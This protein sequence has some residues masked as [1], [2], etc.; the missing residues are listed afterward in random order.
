MVKKL[1]L[2]T[3]LKGSKKKK[4]G[5]NV[6]FRVDSIHQ[7]TKNALDATSLRQEIISSNIANVNTKDYKAKQVIF[8][9]ELK[10]A[11]S[12]S[13]SVMRATDA[14]HFGVGSNV[15]SVQARIV[16]DSEN[17]TMNV[18]GNSIDIELEMSKM[19]A[20][21]I[22]YNALIQSTS[23]RLNDYHSVIKG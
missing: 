19:A 12:S 3:F 18:D 17:L 23:S 7:L 5:E 22:Q 20:N 4:G 21:Q 16:E 1:S 15:S 13:G 14:R 10:E 9:T 2:A 8:E 11:L 6:M